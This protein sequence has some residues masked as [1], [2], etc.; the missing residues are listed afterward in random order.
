MYKKAGKFIGDSGVIGGITLSGNNLTTTGK[1]YCPNVFSGT[2]DLP[3]VNLS[4][5]VPHVHSTGKGY[6]KLLAEPHTLM[7]MSSFNDSQTINKL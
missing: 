6:F 4:W 3:S 5:Y 7:D 1:L 2:G